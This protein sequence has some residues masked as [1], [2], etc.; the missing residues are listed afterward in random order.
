MKNIYSSDHWA[1]VRRDEQERADQRWTAAE[2][3]FET[4]VVPRPAYASMFQNIDVTRAPQQTKSVRSL[5]GQDIPA[6]QFTHNNMQPFFR[7]SVRQSMDPFSTN[8]I[9][10]NHTGRSQY[11][12]HKRETECFFEP[13]GGL[14]NVCGMDNNDDFYKDHLVAPISRRNDF[15][16]EQVRVGRGVGLGYTAEPAGGF[17]Q[18]ATL[19]VIR[20]K[21]VDELRPGNKPKANLEARVQGS[22]KGITQ[23]GLIGD[24]A[25]HRPD[26][27]HEQREDQW[28]KTTGAVK[29]EQGRPVFNMKPT[30]RVE[31]H[32]DYEGHVSG[33]A[34]KPGRGTSD[35]YGK[36]TVIV[37]DNE[38]MT[39]QTRT[40]VSNL[41]STV[42]AIVAP[43]LDVLK[44]GIKEYTIDAARTYGNMAA[45]IPSKPTVY[46]PV[47][48]MMR[49]TI[50]ETTIH[51]TT[52]ANPK[53]ATAVP[54]AAEDKARTTTRETLKLPVEEVV[55]NVS[56]HTYRVTVY[57]PDE[58]AKTTYRELTERAQNEVGY[59]G[60][61]I[62]K[63]VGA[64]SHIDVQVPNTSKQFLSD[65]E[66]VGDAGSK[67]DFRPSSD[68]A[69]YNMQVDGTREA[70]NIASGHT[71]AAGGL[72]VGLSADAVEMESKK[73]ITDSMAVRS[74][75]NVT[76]VVQ[77]GMAP[78]NSC[79]MTKGVLVR[80][81]AQE[82]RLDTSLLA[83]L[84]TNPYNLSINPI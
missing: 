82:G 53:G 63:S 36:S 50:K 19:D 29:K 40:V 39:T 62:E 81:N 46:D 18:A 11:F 31:T 47:N 34:A 54:V 25:K 38:R 12:Q 56:A 66:Y 77:S 45:Q 23:R 58:V 60:G 57:N 16:I 10:E 74:A 2:S 84:K 1:A 26:T 21:C 24:M 35:D 42:K 71:P 14:G 44:H 13:T 8:P 55:R 9:L 43:F 69:A 15:P 3:P 20:P 83:G 33:A 32:V 73:L 17:Q 68:E 80:A 7:G 64:Y 52:L 28:L 67:T 61:G 6:E 59:V 22:G 72:F 51:D 37:Y 4:G 49:T 65:N 30:S 5:S 70:L 78:L 48:H 75:G 76:R 41:T 27:F 79:D